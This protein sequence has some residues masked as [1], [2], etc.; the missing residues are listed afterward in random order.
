MIHVATNIGR[1]ILL[2]LGQFKSEVRE[3][4][5]RNN[6]RREGADEWAQGFIPVEMWKNET[7]CCNLTLNRILK[8]SP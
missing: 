3:I 7:S 8:F 1:V 4:R 2:T 5:L 6:G